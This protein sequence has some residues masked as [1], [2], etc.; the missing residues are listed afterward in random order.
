MRRFQPSFPPFSRSPQDHVFCLGDTTWKL[1]S[2]ANMRDNYSF[3]QLFLNI[4]L[5]AINLQWI[6]LLKVSYLILLFCS[7]AARRDIKSCLNF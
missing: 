1:A 2:F 4:F 3:S 5:A 7:G 6:V